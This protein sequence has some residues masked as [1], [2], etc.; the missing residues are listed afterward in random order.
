MLPS[1]QLDVHERDI[2]RGVRVKSDGFTWIGPPTME[3]IK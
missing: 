1:N 2:A 3:V